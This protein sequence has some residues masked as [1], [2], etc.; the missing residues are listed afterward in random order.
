MIS[1]IL[2]HPRFLPEFQKSTTVETEKLRSPEHFICGLDY[3]WLDYVY[4]ID[5]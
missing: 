3:R 2:N 1:L 5:I 4:I